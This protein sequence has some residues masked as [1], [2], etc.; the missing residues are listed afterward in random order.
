MSLNPRPTA[1]TDPA[2]RGGLSGWQE[3]RATELLVADLTSPAALKDVA[4]GCGI[5]V[6]HFNRG[7]RIS[8]GQSPRQRLIG[9]RIQKAKR[10]LLE[11][12]NS[13]IAIA[14]E[15]GFSDQSH[16]TRMFARHVGQA[17]GRWR[18]MQRVAGPAGG[19]PASA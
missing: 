11:T 7:F 9:Y 13:L 19:K 15:C 2:H 5:S 4:T 16:F 10:L 3:K 14:F 18:Q 8:T 17:P 6:G 1:T 12:S